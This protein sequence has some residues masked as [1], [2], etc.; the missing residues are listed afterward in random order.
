VE[1]CFPNY[2]YF[3]RKEKRKQDR[4]EKDW[5]TCSKQTRKEL[6]D[7]KMVK[8]L[9]FKSMRFFVISVAV[10][11]AIL[12]FFHFAKRYF[13]EYCFRQYRKVRN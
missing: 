6:K 3:Y 2:H 7:P 8:R 4:E 1:A 5:R 12:F 9:T 13:E 11:T 10:E